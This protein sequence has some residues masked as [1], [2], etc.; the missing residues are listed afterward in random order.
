MKSSLLT[1]LAAVL[2]A[3]AAAAQQE[4]PAALR[5]I[6]IDQKLDAQVPLDAAFRDEAGRSVRLG[7]YCDGKKPVVLVLAYYKCPRLCSVV[8]NGVSDSLRRIAFELKNE[9]TVVTVSFDPRE[10]PD[11]AAAKRQAYLDHLGVPGVAWHFL[12]GEEP[13]IR[14]LA[15][16]VGFR[17]VYDAKKDE[18]RHGSG[19]MVLTPSGRVSRYFYG[20]TFPPRD[21]RLG[22]V[23]ASEGRIGTATDQLLLSC[24][25]YD[26]ETGQY[27][28]V[29]LKLVRL[30]GIVTVLILAVVLVRAWRRERR[31][32][33]PTIV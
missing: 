16:A 6:G 3:G 33:Q 30:G 17:Y 12:T 26:P 14:R 10:G 28:L 1:L 2:T 5:E 31:S 19:I 29:A 18:Y 9:F 7:D 4:L 32:A 25:G 27:R 13:A 15:A 8:L 22:L 21:L 23:E 11:L 20:V 24:F